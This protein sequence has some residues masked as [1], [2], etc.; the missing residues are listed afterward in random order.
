LKGKGITIEK[1]IKNWLL[2]RS[3]GDGW[4][5]LL[6]TLNIDFNNIEIGFSK[7]SVC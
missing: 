1:L 2:E 5:K 4:E 3:I 6:S 7:Y